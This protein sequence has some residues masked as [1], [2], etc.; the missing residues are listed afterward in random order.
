MISESRLEEIEKYFW[1]ES[2]DEDT[3]IWRDELNTEEQELIDEWDKR[4]DKAIT[5]LT[6]EIYKI[7]QKK[8]I[9]IDRS[10]ND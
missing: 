8:I 3:Q 7:E 1:A 9:N 4:V 10:R 6:N 5:K 2:N